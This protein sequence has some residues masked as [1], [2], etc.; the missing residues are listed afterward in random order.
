MIITTHLA[1]G[2]GLDPPNWVAKPLTF[3]CLL[4]PGSG[5]NLPA[6]R[7]PQSPEGLAMVTANLFELGEEIKHQIG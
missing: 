4:W 6:K 5:C 7:M 3:E 2:A 1:R